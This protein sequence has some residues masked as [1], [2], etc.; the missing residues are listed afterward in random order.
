MASLQHELPGDEPLPTTGDPAVARR[1]NWERGVQSIAFVLREL[2]RAHPALDPRRV[3]LVGHSNGGDMA[4][5]FAREHPNLVQRVISLDNRRMPLP[6][7]RRPR[8]LSL[9]SADQPA[10]R[11]VLPTPAEQARF[12]T[13]I[14]RLPHTR[15]NDMWDGA[16]REQQ[17]EMLAPIARFLNE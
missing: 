9:R 8:V 4:M 3:L 14:I 5:L 6:R 17:Q 2:Q 15:H 16:T 7:A 12:G 10:D 1:P 13:Q 11:G